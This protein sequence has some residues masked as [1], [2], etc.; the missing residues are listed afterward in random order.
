[1]TDRS[2]TDRRPRRFQGSMASVL[3]LAGL[4]GDTVGCRAGGAAVEEMRIAVNQVAYLASGK[5]WA[6][7]ASDGPAR[8]WRVEDIETREVV[9]KGR[10]QYRGYDSAS[11]QHLH[12]IDFSS[13]SR[14]GAYRLWVE[15]M[16]EA[17]PL[18]VSARP[19]RDLPTRAMG[20]FYF[21]R[22][23]A[24]IERA[25]LEYPEHARPA[26]HPNGH[27]VSAREGWTSH[28]FDV[29]HGWADAGDFGLYPVNHAAA[30]WHLA[31]LFERYRAFDDGTL[32]IPEKNNGR[33]DLLDELLYGSRYLEGMLPP[34]GL[35]AH[36][37]HG[38][39]WSPFPVSVEEEN[40]LSRWA[41]PPSTNATWAIARTYAHLARLVSQGSPKLAAHLR[42]VAKEAYR[43][44]EAQPD[45]DYLVEKEDGG[46]SYSDHTN[47]DDRYAASVE[48]FL[49]TAEPR[50]REAVVTSP[51]YGE[52]GAF[53]WKHTA[54]T[55]TLSL[56]SASSTL[57]RQDIDRM[58]ARLIA[59]A[60]TV[61]L[62]IVSGGYPA[63][64]PPDGYVWGSNGAVLNDMVIL[65]VAY[66]LG[67][68][69]RHIDGLFLAMDY[70]M[71]LNAVGRSFVT[72]YGRRRERDLHDRL[73]WGAYQRGVPFPSGWVA[74]GPNDVLINDEA[75]PRA[76]PP[77]KS[78]AAL[79]TAPTAWC[80][81][82]NAINWNA[83]LVWVA[84]YVRHHAGGLSVGRVRRTR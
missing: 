24:A 69:Q 46:G 67:R 18:E 44:A 8:G 33:S 72:G 38:G 10:S 83:S 75:T 3:A 32:A 40:R 13:L 63:P 61:V 82:E 21:H 48:L 5:K 51:H 11:N 4:A 65:A 68:R 6:V 42:S 23:G 76:A 16:K 25:Y 15:G 50:F 52:V 55:G 20:Y 60:D 36:K 30:A 78:Y 27:Q 19:Y 22:L 2:R 80:S 41:M 47:E 73:A 35:A 74:G 26:L 62:R 54:T 77:A 37:V 1:M 66:D 45:V 70:L 28:V 58:K 57:P 12:H 49:T 81:K 64:L 9:A 31:N 84:W 71:G 43:R 34:T 59:Y 56:L 14:P 17:A 79:N 53:D 39:K 29:R 7:F